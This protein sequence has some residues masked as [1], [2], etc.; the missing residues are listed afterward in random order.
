MKASIR[1]KAITL[2]ENNKRN[3]M[4]DVTI[5]KALTRKPNELINYFVNILR[6]N[7]IHISVRFC[8][9]FFFDFWQF[10]YD[11]YR[12]RCGHL[13]CVVSI[14]SKVEREWENLIGPNWPCNVFDETPSKMNRWKLQMNHSWLIRSHKKQYKLL[15]AWDANETSLYIAFI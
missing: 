12:S 5:R 8:S 7:A 3:Q 15:I 2:K 14:G 1:C 13:K 6:Y 11:S 4:A 9:F 10:L